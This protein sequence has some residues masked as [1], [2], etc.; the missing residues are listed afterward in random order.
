MEPE[1]KAIV[2]EAISRGATEQEIHKLVME[3]YGVKKK[4]ETSP[5]PAALATGS[6][7][8]PS[9]TAVGGKPSASLSDYLSKPQIGGATVPQYEADVLEDYAN[10]FDEAYAQSIVSL[11]DVDRFM[12]GVGGDDGLAPEEY[13]EFEASYAAASTEQEKLSVKGDL[14]DYLSDKGDPDYSANRYLMAGVSQDVSNALRGRGPSTGNYAKVPVPLEELL[15]QAETM[16]S[17]N[18]AQEYGKRLRK[19]IPEEILSNPAEVSKYERH[20]FDNYSLAVDLNQDRYIG[21]QE[22]LDKG[23]GGG[24]GTG[25]AKA[26]H[27]TMAGGNFMM[28]DA[29]GAV[30]GKDNWF[31]RWAVGAGEKSN[32]LA[33]EASANLPIPLERISDKTDRVLGGDWGDF[34]DL[35][36]DYLRMGGE[37]V[38]MMVAA[39]AAGIATR[40]RV[41]GLAKA[42]GIDPRRVSRVA[43][44][45]SNRSAFVVTS[46]MGMGTAYN[47]VRGEEW[48]EEMSNV[49][50]IAYTSIMGVS[51]GLPAMVAANISVRALSGIG[52]EAKASF[53][54]GF[55]KQTGLGMAEEGATEAVTAGVQYLT[56]IGFRKD[57]EWDPLEFTKAVK[58][59][60][61]AGVVL[62]GVVSTTFQTPGI[63]FA[64]AMA[65][66][67][68]PS[69]RDQFQIQKLQEE[70]DGEANQAA[71]AVIGKKLADAVAK[72]YDRKLKRTKFYEQ[73]RETN[74]T[75][76]GQLTGIQKKI[77]KLGLDYSRVTNVDSKAE[78]KGQMTALIEER[79]KIENELGME[80]DLNA[81]SEFKRVARAIGRID[82]RYNG[83]GDLF[84]KGE[85]TVAVT[86]ENVD[87]VLDAI[88]QATFDS[89]STLADGAPRT[90]DQMKQ[91]LLNT[92]KLVKALSKSAGFKAVHI[93]RTAAA[94]SSATGDQPISRGLWQGKGD[95][96]M[97]MPAIQNN[98]AYHE[99]FHDIVLERLG[100]EGVTAL[101]ARL[102]KGLSGDTKT[103]YMAF[104]RQYGD[105]SGIKKAI[106]ENPA[107]AEEFLVELLGDLAANNV[108]IKVQKGLVNSFKSFVSTVANVIPGMDVDWGEVSPRLDDMVNAIQK[109]TGQMASG[110]AIT[111][112]EDI[113]KAA[114][115]MGYSVMAAAVA[116]MDPKAQGIYARNRDVEQITDASKFSAAMAEATERMMELKNKVFLQVDTLTTEDVQEILDE[117]GQLF[118]T[119]D[120]LAGAY[121]KADG[122]M[123]G[124]FK[125]P[126]SGFKLVSSPLQN[127]RERNGGKFYDAFGTGLEE[128]YINN[129]WRPVARLDFNP[130]FAPEGWDDSNSPLKDQPD[131]V[132]FVKGEG[133]IG[134]G[135][136]LTDYDEAYAYA[137]SVAN[138]K[139]QH[140]F[141]KSLEN[142]PGIESFLK[143]EGVT[144]EQLAGRKEEMKL[145]ESQR[146]QRDPKVLES[147]EKYS[148][149]QITQSDYLK[150]VSGEMPI[151]SFL[152]SPG[153]PSTLDVGAALQS[154]KLD[155]GIIGVNKELP[156]GY[157]VALRL[158]IPAYNEYDIWVVSVHQGAKDTSVE[159]VASLGGKSIG[160]AQ[161]GW[162]SNVS[163]ESLPKAAFNIAKGKGKTT[164]ARMFGDWKTHSPEELNA[165]A[166]GIMSGE[167]YNSSD[168]AVGKLDGWIQVGMNPFRHSWFY[169]KRD[170]NPVVSASEVIQ[171]GALVLARNVEKV[172]V[173]DERF[174]LVRPDGSVVK[175]Q[176]L[177]PGQEGLDTNESFTNKAQKFGRF[178]NKYSEDEKS[179]SNRIKGMVSH[180]VSFDD[181]IRGTR[182]VSS[183]PDNM[184]VGNVY[185]DDTLI[186]SGGGG[187]YYP[188]RTGNV[189]AVAKAKEAKEI[190]DKL[191]EIRESSPDGKAR[192][193]LVRGGD[194]KLFSNTGAIIASDLMLRK[195]ID[196]GSLTRADHDSLL[197]ESFKLTYPNKDKKGNPTDRPVDLEGGVEE[198]AERVL[199]HMTDVTAS[200]FGKRSFFSNKMF[201]L[202][203][204]MLK[205]NAP[206]RL[207]I[208]E[209]MGT[210]KVGQSQGGS[211]PRRVI[212][213]M[214]TERFLQGLPGGVVYGAIEVDSEVR[215]EMDP[216]ETTFP[217]SVYQVDSKGEKKAP[218]L[219]LFK[220]KPMASD[221]FRTER[222]FDQPSFV[223]TFS[224][225][226]YSGQPNPEGSAA[227]AWAALLGLRNQAFGVASAP[228]KAQAISMRSDSDA[229]AQGDLLRLISQMLDKKY[230]SPNISRDNRRK[231]PVTAIDESFQLMLFSSVKKDVIKTLTE[232]GFDLPA[233]ERMYKK[234]VAYKEGRSQG[235]REGL[236]VA[237]HNAKGARKLSTKAISLKKSLEA[238]RDKSKTFN[239]FL[240]Q[241]IEL[242]AERMK[243]NSKTPFTKSQLTSLVKYIRQA[244]KTSG[245]KV[246]EQGIDSMQSFID[247]I[248]VI[249]DERDTK[250][251]MQR[252]LDGI[253]HAQ[254]LQKRLKKA[255]KVRGRAAA[256]RSVATYAKIA[257]GLARI[258]PAL[259]P[260]AELE[261]FINTLMQTIS[262]VSKTK[263]VFDESIEAYVGVTP[264]KTDAETLY[265][266]LSNYLAMEELGRQ[267]LFMARAEVKAIKNG[268]SV[269]E[270]YNNI[271]R[272]YERGRLSASR[273]AVMDFIDE[274]P[275]VKDEQGNDINL[276]ESNPAHLEL[277]SKLLAEQAADSEMLKKEAIINDVLIPRIAA[278]IVKLLEDSHIAEILGIHNAADLDFDTLRDRLMLLHRH[279]VIN[280][281]YRLDDYIV[282]DSL[283]GVGYLHS[284][285]KGQIDMPNKLR[286]LIR[287]AGLQAR[288]K[289]VLGLLDT[290]DSYL[291]N[292][293]VTDRLSF[294]KLRIAIGLANLTRDFA[295]ADFLH[296]QLVQMIEAEI[297]R[298]SDEG[299]NVKTRKDRAIMQL[300]SMAKQLPAFEGERGPAEAAWY[301]EL[302]GAMKRSIDS[303]I[304][305]KSFTKEEIEEFEDAF[306]YLFA[307]AE[308]LSGLISRVESE[309]SDVVELVQYVADIHTA[310]MPQFKNYVER[311][312]GKEL[313]TE[314]NYTA[315]EVIPETGA[316]SIDDLLK[317]RMSLQ[318]ALASSSLSQS[319]KVAGSSFERNPRSLKGNAK[320][321]LDFLGIN[322]RVIRDNVILT[323]T[324]GSIVTASHVMNSDA[325][326]S[327][328][329]NNAARTELENKIMLYVQQDTGKVPS[330]FKP[331]VKI[332]GVKIINPLNLLRNAVVV[333]AFGG[334]AIQTLKQST[335]LISVVFQTQ[336]PIKAIPHLIQ[337]LAEVVFF[338]IKNGFGKDSKLALDNGRYKLLQNS[339]VFQRDYEA[340]NIDPHTG[341][342]SLD[343][344]KVSEVIR[345]LTDMSLKNLKGTDKVAAVSSWF[346]FYGDALISEGI[347]DGY[348]EIDWE[349]EAANPN[350]VALSHADAMVSK[351]Q[352][353]STPRQAAALYQE[354]GGKTTA[355]AYLAKNI[356]MPFARFAINKKRSITSDLMRLKR[357]DAATK[358]EAGIALVGHVTELTLF[359]TIG[360][361]LLPAI[362]S[363]I[364]S[365][366]F[367]EEEEDELPRKSRWRSV[368]GNV[369]TDL[370]PLPPLAVV[371]DQ[372]KSLFNRFV[373]YPYDAMKHGDYNLGDNDGYERWKRVEGGIPVFYKGKPKDAAQG[374]MRFFGPYGDFMD[375][376]RTSIQNVGVPNNKVVTSS[377][378]EYYVRPED[379]DAMQLHYLAKSLFVIGQVAGI[380]SKELQMIVREL[381]DLPRN[382]RLS[383]EESL[384]AYESIAMKFGSEFEGVAGEDR[385]RE[386][387]AGHD[388]DFDKLRAA[389]S[390]RSA[391]KPLAVEKHLEKEFPELYKA[392]IREIRP[393]VKQLSNARDYHA[394]LRSKRATLSFEDY[395]GLKEILDI[396][397]GSIRPSFYI[398]QTY[399]DLTNEE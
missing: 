324:V 164:I 123:G 199:T 258:N 178:S 141:I 42:R 236:R 327:L 358:K 109:T 273:K 387:I 264:V 180:N 231:N 52:K 288:A 303:Y 86:S 33:V 135:I 245:K 55:L 323:N 201:V 266:K 256:A 280:L 309:R 318:G 76:W 276:D 366:L 360:Q 24:F 188:V 204:Q 142:K 376:M 285:I 219:L 36:G 189:W 372:I 85:D 283:Y 380:S 332:R 326:K 254:S 175:F 138:G 67:S 243:E 181:T 300:Y 311:Y 226:K 168:L 378:T 46:A 179:F 195:L 167:D 394:F 379:K 190:A 43:H 71:R 269:E 344:G 202:L 100:T 239:E 315:F 145:E 59:G 4:E 282:N 255:A 382:R 217:A 174:N 110:E 137:S 271:V 1:L 362:A 359:H 107:V 17:G 82:K 241:A 15:P 147:L 238:L 125:N 48:F 367:G 267:S 8:S 333:K 60:L 225:S 224:K 229:K 375:D 151:T 11:F 234:A 368:F 148:V 304:E 211:I 84:K 222:G 371:D 79:S 299:G 29:V 56:E 34:D 3:F 274:N 277:I 21:G 132:F 95:I 198:V 292:L 319:K 171:I 18:I 140:V 176:H 88:H 220:D 173:T 251:E 355:I 38:P 115:R 205:D 279:Q 108:E 182:F 307:P 70:Y 305:Q 265:N 156:E 103:K 161:T 281:D 68:I 14:I 356:L 261:G 62:G 214:L 345:K 98:T 302:R 74:E 80:Y 90:A 384:A 134:E 377:G 25:V 328:I 169:D 262:S 221:V 268:T 235:L 270:E 334:F 131:V 351:D 186:F 197:I 339:P 83:Y 37:S 66:T 128:L 73:L 364:K 26:W 112:V 331:H 233:A 111:G 260:Q 200:T 191:N 250:R 65:L 193:V 313:E 146:P 44:K 20:L 49:E 121:L 23:L 122:Y 129:G 294:A 87:E 51:E 347:V 96:H 81:Q 342:M 391:L 353:A 341:R 32:Q 50:K 213:Q 208:Q 106:K 22:F 10:S 363:F 244:H 336:N 352:A 393:L 312:L 381:D 5:S 155:A 284:L 354:Q 232:A 314:K 248:S 196:S 293:V 301:L 143:V 237:M 75:A 207:E 385:I 91:S 16:V 396:Y 329:P 289:N 369:L 72:S 93:H 165:L 63:V 337:T 390:Y 92:I 246:K 7:E 45:H 397:I 297:E 27:D 89:V 159:R 2:D 154:N 386:V 61:Y 321:G 316:R 78:L 203:G 118:M 252:Y 162:I 6:T 13:R 166:E 383:N 275:T 47:A 259:L 119:K 139:A 349:A 373:L 170:G 104:L 30:F 230:P 290:V 209:I 216:N 228:S 325:M 257:E 317:L 330:F 31:T 149:H 308:T 361:V 399:L 348:E 398:E 340:G 150:I 117:G 58:D 206:A 77:I 120:G 163:F 126:D 187:V 28:G 346:V 102:F 320:I 278:N 295:K 263:A 152:G 136:R 39:L 116:D 247:R 41:K 133:V 114:R 370:N 389:R 298:I 130:E 127:T 94:W 306:N 185:F 296:S 240:G 57:K 350:E 144:E 183:S 12:A 69:I 287:S 218:K 253:R 388:N 99:G 124:L 160:Y 35:A 310:L 343:E 210:Q 286:R 272:R 158:D 177:L 184:M 223:E 53:V 249:F 365:T 101:A 374:M 227:S 338:N 157:Y 153:V 242:V 105:F 335:V 291:A 9:A 97:Y 357:G 192:F 194:E 54:K 40:G 212:S 392:H 395:T 113:A 322:E 64:G 19:H 215:F 172:S